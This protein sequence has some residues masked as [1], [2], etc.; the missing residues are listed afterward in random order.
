MK[1]VLAIIVIVALAAMFIA[2][3]VV[4]RNKR[5]DKMKNIL[6]VG[7]RIVFYRNAPFFEEFE[8]IASAEITECGE[9]K[10]NY[11]TDNNKAIND[12]YS[13]FGMPNTAV[14]VEVYDGDRLVYTNYKFN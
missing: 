9:K 12:R 8:Y 14:A 13:T 2:A 10:F 3:E 7:M 1:N 5:R 6:K 11:K 4:A